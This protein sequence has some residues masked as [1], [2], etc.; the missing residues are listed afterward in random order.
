M[1]T[2][3]LIMKNLI[4]K[5]ALEGKFTGNPHVIN[6]GDNSKP[7]GVFHSGTEISDTWH[8]I[9]V[10]ENPR[11]QP[12]DPYVGDPLSGEVRRSGEYQGEELK[13]VEITL[14]PRGPFLGVPGP[15][16]PGQRR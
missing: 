12:G 1:N 8:I 15:R 2:V 9:Q 3:N 11:V 5:V 10:Y 13:P 7:G 16:V 4:D 14:D 6:M